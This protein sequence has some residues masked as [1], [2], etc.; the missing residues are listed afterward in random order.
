MPQRKPSQGRLKFEIDND[1]EMGS[2]KLPEETQQDV[3]HVG[4]FFLGI[5]VELEWVGAACACEAP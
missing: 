4:F 5:L 1:L 3:F 2:K